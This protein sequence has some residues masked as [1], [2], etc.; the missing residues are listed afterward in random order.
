[1]SE[2]HPTACV[3]CE[4]NCGIEVKVSE[5]GQRIEKV[6]GDPKHPGSQGYLCQKA[7]RLDHYQNSVDR[8]LHP[9]KRTPDGDYEQISWEQAISEVAEKLSAIRDKFGGDKLFY[10]GGGG[11]GNHL[12]GGYGMT[13][14]TALGGRYRTNS[15]AQEKTGE[16]WVSA[17]MFG[18]YA[19]R[20]DF[21]HCEVG[22]FI[23]K[24]PWNSHGVQRSRV[25]LREIA[26][27]PNRALVVFDPRV[28]ETAD[29]ANFHIQL[30]PGTDAWALAAIIAIFLQEDLVDWKW[31]KD[32]VTG[33]DKVLEL[34]KHIDVSSYANY[35][36]VPE[37]NLRQL[38]QRLA[39]AKSIA[40][41]EDLGVQMN[42]NS[43]LVSY[44]HRIAWLVTGSFGKQGS[45]FIPN[46][47]RPLMSS[48]PSL[49]RK[50]P[51]LG[52][53]ILSGLVPCNIVAEEILTDHP[54]RYR[55]MVIES[56]NPA[57]STADTKKFV[58]A[59]RS[60]ECTVVIDVAMTETA[61]NADYVLPASTQYEKAEATFFNFEYPNNYF[62]L[63][64]PVFNPPEGSET[65]PEAEI[66]SRLLSAIGEMPEEITL[67]KAHLKEH[68]RKGFFEKFNEVAGINGDIQKY[69]PVVLYETLGKT[70]PKGLEQSA[71][72]WST[73][74][75]V[76]NREPDSL[77]RAGIDGEGNEVG[78]NLFDA[79]ISNPNGIIFS[80]DEESSS[81]TRVRTGDHRIKADIPELFPE[82]ESL[83]TGP[84]SITNEDYPFV[85]SAGERR[86][87]TANCVIRNPEWRKKDQEGALRLS[88]NDASKL[89]LQTGD[90]AQLST[91]FGRTKV[92]VE[93]SSRMM[94]GHISLPNGQGMDTRD[95][96]GEV[97]RKGTATNELTGSGHRDFFA[98]TPWHKYIPANITTL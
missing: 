22:I 52:A 91:A 36:G 84:K 17:N 57:H 13:T 59:M 46:T 27:D 24:N 83:K 87:Y 53:P 67:L 18:G 28:S 56:S 14:M 44:I 40:W 74:H 89:G 96:A 80:K 68:G 85:L 25:E 78:E 37:D 15:L 30:K 90:A 41:Y 51:V 92:T 16:G 5:D 86:P 76:A 32:N 35:C 62:H 72:L 19:Q 42:R 4:N 75:F 97:E 39:E 77:R 34:F 93:V 71:I 45:Q 63:R 10:Y 58:K 9:L 88:L 7:S 95:E 6:K 31:L 54:D 43:T 3:L 82:I 69:A 2:W 26:K 29:I 48:N 66:H 49:S 94:D 60:L 79:M 8:I 65:L 1:M 12:P 38:A 21:E 70:L 33:Y 64:H 61:R 20:G 11:Q 98:G 73:A 47:I 81:W 55:G 50:S 23:G